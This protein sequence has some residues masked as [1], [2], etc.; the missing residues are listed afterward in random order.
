MFSV[1]HDLRASRIA[2]PAGRPSILGDALKMLSM[3]FAAGVITSLALFLLAFAT[4]RAAGAAQTT[5][6]A[7]A[8]QA[9]SAAGAAPT[10]S[11]PGT[12]QGTPALLSLND[13]PA[14]SRLNDTTRGTLYFANGEQFFVAPQVSTRVALKVTGPIVRALVTQKFHNPTTEWLEGV[15]AFPLPEDAA[16]DHLTLRVGERVIVGEIREKQQAKREYEQAKA[17]GKRASLL[18]QTRPNLFSSRLANIAP[19][20]TVQVEIE[21]QNTVKLVGGKYTLRFPLVVAQRYMPPVTLVEEADAGCGGDEMLDNII[22]TALGEDEHDEHRSPRVPAQT[23]TGPRNPVTIA[24]DLEPGVELAELA[25]PSHE[26]HVQRFEKGRSFVSLLNKE[27]PADR[28]FELT[29][30]PRLTTLPQP[31]AFTEAVNG[32]TFAVVTLTPPDVKLAPSARLNRDAIF[33]IDTSGSMQGASIVQAKAAL[34]LALERLQPSDRFNVIEFNSITR[35][36][37]PSTVPVTRENIA[38]AKAWV[39]KLSAN[40]GTEMLPALVSALGQATSPSPAHVRQIL[41]LT[42]GAVANE[43]E[44]IRL[45]DTH[46]GESRLFTVGIGS[47]PNG[48]FLRKA[49]ELG[50]GSATFIARIDE[51]ATKMSTLFEKLETPVLSELSIDAGPDVEVW[52]KRLPDLY[53]GEPLTLTLRG[54]R[55]PPSIALAGKNGVAPWRSVVPVGA[56][57]AE[58]GVATLWARAKIESLTDAE[59]FTKDPEGIRK[60]IVDVAL[61]HHLVSKYTSLIAVEKTPA[62]PNDAA[63]KSTRIA[64]ATPL[65]EAPLAQTATAAQLSWL[66]GALLFFTAAGLGFAPMVSVRK[67]HK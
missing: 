56:P 37:F 61:A 38:H 51:V 6:A 36:L 50:R 30:A 41:F 40:G 2:V 27:V 39:D 60:A 54:K 47:A 32:E 1:F 13:L 31:S 5:S 18:E 29:W 26:V 35:T 57:Q 43:D 24:V 33:I 7:G 45:V 48:Y 55:L 66:L 25:S 53:A 11:A 42:D 10:T 64:L 14:Q 4:A 8:A 59:R 67:P 62:R 65:N 16:V 9:T 19:N 20:E 46:A 15:Y 17:S 21:Y 49:A 3:A 23:A 58:S 52:P 12:A 22:H 44:V 63:L 34:T 28:D